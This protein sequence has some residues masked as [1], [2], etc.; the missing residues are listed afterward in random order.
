MSEFIYLF[1]LRDKREKEG[2]SL[3]VQWL[4]LRA[5]NAGDLGLIPG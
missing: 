5:T 4:R 1:L 2:T 3:A